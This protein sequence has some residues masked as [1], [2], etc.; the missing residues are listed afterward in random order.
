MKN[1]FLKCIFLLVPLS[2]S[3]IAQEATQ[4]DAEAIILASCGTCHTPTHRLPFVDSEKKVIWTTIETNAELIYEKVSTG[5]MPPNFAPPSAKITDGQRAT[6]LSYIETLIKDEEPKPQPAL[7]LDR[8]TMPKGFSIEVY[9]AASGARSL[10]VHSSGIVFVGTGGATTSGPRDRVYAIVPSGEGRAA[11]VVDFITGLNSPNGVAIHGDDL[12]VAEATRVIRFANATAAAEALAS[13]ATTVPTYT[14]IKEDFAVQENHFWK[15]LG[16]GPD[17][18]IYVPI[19]ADCNVCLPEDR[20]STAGI[21]RM[22]LDGSNYEQVAMGVR[23]TVGFDWD[24]ED[25]ELWFTDN[26]RDLLGDNIPSDELNHLSS[27]EPPLDFGFPY[28]FAKDVTDPEFGIGQ[29]CAGAQFVKPV[30]ELGA[31][32]AALGLH[33]YR[34]NVFPGEYRNQMFVAEHGSWNRTEKSGYRVRAVQELRGSGGGSSPMLSDNEFISG[35]LDTATQ[36]NWGRPV[37][38]K[39]FTDGSLL[40]SDD[41]AGVVYRVSYSDKK[42]D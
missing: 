11:K 19:G 21:F 16:I 10:A 23:N 9:A 25:A 5:Q 18:K 22:D 34:G 39:T 32:V 14:V 27:K 12:Y 13:G 33:F 6:F 15:Y 4:A 36:V 17:G 40:I 37:D 2:T 35:W 29:N 1:R 30:V 8:L 38:V 20:T 3:V 31:H 26:G 41:F 24:P 42:V 28:C 7:P